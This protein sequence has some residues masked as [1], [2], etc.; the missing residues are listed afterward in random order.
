[1]DKNTGDYALFALWLI[2][3]SVFQLS[4]GDE[5]SEVTRNGYESKELVYLVHIHCQVIKTS[6]LNIQVNGNSLV[7]FKIPFRGVSYCK[8]IHDYI[9]HSFARNVANPESSKLCF[10][11][12]ASCRETRHKPLQWHFWFSINTFLSKW[13]H[14]MSLAVPHEAAA[15]QIPFSPNHWELFKAR[16]IL[17]EFR[18][19]MP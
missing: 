16:L 11:T 1:M 14:S 17:F 18:K 3:F 7:L 5:Q 12:P 15:V 10:S 4:L 9:V 13:S 8:M 6:Q 19:K 2:W